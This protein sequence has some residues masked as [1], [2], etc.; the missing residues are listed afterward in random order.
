MSIVVLAKTTLFE[1]SAWTRRRVTPGVTDTVLVQCPSQADQAAGL[2]LTST[3]R[4]SITLAEPK[5]LALAVVVRKKLPET[6]SE[7]L[8]VSVSG[9]CERTTDRRLAA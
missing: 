6:G 9:I 4:V 1:S 3:W 2:P 7:L 5:T 8:T